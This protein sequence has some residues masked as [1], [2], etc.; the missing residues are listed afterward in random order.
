LFQAPGRCGRN[1]SARQSSS[2]RR[3][4][5]PRSHPKTR[6]ISD[7]IGDCGRSD[8][9]VRRPRRSPHRRGGSQGIEAQRRV[10]ALEVAIEE[11]PPPFPVAAPMVKSSK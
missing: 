2:P 7:R 5:R 8:S 11:T 3:F 6:H 1:A 4:G 10:E 9:D